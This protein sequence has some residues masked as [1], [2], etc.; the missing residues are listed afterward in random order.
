MNNSP[1]VFQRGKQLI[2]YRYLMKF[3]AGD[4]IGWKGINDSAIEK[5][6]CD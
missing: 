4:E 3:H 2:K 5:E 1:G 6:L